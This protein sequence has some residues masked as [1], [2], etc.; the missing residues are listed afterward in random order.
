MRLLSQNKLP[1]KDTHGRQVRYLR[2]SVTDRCNLRCKYCV[3]EIPSF[4]PHSNILRYEEMRRLVEQF[5]HLGVKKVRLTGGEPFV[6]KGFVDFIESLMG[7]YPDLDLRITTNATLLEPHIRRLAQAGIRRLNISLDT[8]DPE[9]FAKITGRDMYARVRRSIDTCLDQGIAIKINA[10]AMHDVTLGQ[11]P[12]FLEF[13]R[14]RPVDVRFIELMPIGGTEN[15]IQQTFIPVAKLLSELRK[16]VS[17]VPL[18]QNPS[19]T[20]GPAKVYEVA[21]C[22]G[23]FGV[24]TPMSSHSCATCNRVRVTSDGHLRTCLYS[25]KTYRLRGIIRHPRLGMDKVMEVIRLAGRSKPEGYKLLQKLSQ[26]S[27]VCR[28]AMTSIGG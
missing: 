11:L 23:R 14:Q 3:R 17:L 13:I 22:Q 21:G 24:I 1:L 6:R 19:V 8:L 28:T 20:N 4:I 15:G 7:H 16:Q 26:G 27:S 12:G 25:D 10:V 2:L 18:A 9:M 5:R